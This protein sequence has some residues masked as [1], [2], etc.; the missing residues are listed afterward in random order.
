MLGFIKKDILMVRGNIKSLATILI[1]YGLLGISENMDISFIIPF[2]S[3]TIMMSTFSYDSYNN[4]NAYS[5]SFPNGRTNSVKS[6]YL[7]TI[8]MLLVLSIITIT[9]TLLI[10]CFKHTEINFMSFS[11]IIVT[12]PVT[13]I[14]LAL[15]Y[16]II[17]KFGIE[18]AR[19]AIFVVVFVF[20]ISIGLIIKGINSLN[21]DGT[22]SLINL[23]FSNKYIL[24][25]LIA[26]II[27]LSVYLSYRISLK[28][29]MKKEF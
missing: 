24:I 28:I 5:S 4:F 6:K 18:K 9:I 3:V 16:P 20:T 25:L 7:S 12:I 23:I 15:F 2:L 29:Y 19:I 10:S 11:N 13:L 1:M 27:I 17:Y 22:N 21:F 26:M 8:L 14:I